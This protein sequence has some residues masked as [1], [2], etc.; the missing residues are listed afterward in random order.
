MSIPTPPAPED[1]VPP[2]P[3]TGAL[4]NKLHDAI[5][6]HPVLMHLVD[7]V[8]NLSTRLDAAEQA[9][10]ELAGGAA[11]VHIR[12]QSPDELGGGEDAS[13]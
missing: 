9:R 4:L 13:G 8:Q 1:E 12:P 3:F 10:P 11:E 5:S 6:T 2:P 7:M